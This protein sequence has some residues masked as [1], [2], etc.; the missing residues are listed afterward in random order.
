MYRF[1]KGVYSN[2]REFLP[3]D[4]YGMSWMNDY[5]TTLELIIKNSYHNNYSEKLFCQ[6]YNFF[7]VFFSSSQNNFF[8]Q[9]IV[10]VFSSIK[11]TFLSDFWHIKFEKCKALKKELNEELMPI[12]WRPKRWWDFCTSE[13]EKKQIEPPFTE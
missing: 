4:S 3:W 10:L 5:Y 11:T 1:K 2:A 12:V 7:F 13:D 9:E 8:A 6:A